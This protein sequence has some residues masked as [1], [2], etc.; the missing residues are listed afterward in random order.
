MNSISAL[1]LYQV[2]ANAIFYVFVEE[3]AGIRQ[4]S[5]LNNWSISSL[6]CR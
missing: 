5:F 4:S 1:I 3:P 2:F 6:G